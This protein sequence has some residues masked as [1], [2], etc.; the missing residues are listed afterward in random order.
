MRRRGF[1]K[2]MMGAAAAVAMNLSLASTPKLPRPKEYADILPMF[3]E[4]ACKY[5]GDPTDHRVFDI[6][7][8]CGV[9]HRETASRR[10]GCWFRCRTDEIFI[11]TMMKA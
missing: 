4:G 8:S 7:S 2:L 10:L 1:L 3:S 11:E 6:T 9:D 5:C